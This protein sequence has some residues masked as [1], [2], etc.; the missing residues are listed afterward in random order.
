MTENRMIQAAGMTHQ[1]KLKRIGDS[2]RTAYT[3][4]D[5]AFKKF[6]GII[7]AIVLFGSVTKATITKTSDIDV[8]IVV[9]D[10]TLTPTRR[11]IDWY[12]TEI[13]TL[14]QH[15]DPRLHITTVTLT[16]FWENVKVGEPVAINILRYGVSLVDT[17][18]FEPIQ[19]LLKQGR[20]RPTE[21]AI[22]NAL[23]R[24][25]GHIIRAKGRM[26][27][28][29][30][31]FYWA[32]IDSAHAALMKHNV[33]PPSP[34]HVERLLNETF[35]SKGQL[36]SKYVNFFHELWQTSKAIVHGEV[37]RL[38]GADYDGFERM[39][40]EFEKEMRRLIEKRK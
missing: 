33:V 11:F 30:V 18:F 10:T 3:F 37:T 25:P 27:A 20:I 28:A 31:D 5:K 8:M 35:V 17:G 6:P 2:Y 9:D 15:T 36:K 1:E 13:I 38:G 22:E 21:E 16:T 26:L 7:K 4:A 14:V 34:E 32:M 19:I 24:V 40:E 12:N 29:V 23:M 39:T